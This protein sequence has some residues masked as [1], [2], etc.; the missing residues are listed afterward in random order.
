MNGENYTTDSY[1]ALTAAKEAID[2]LA[3]QDK[4]AESGEGERVYPERFIEAKDAFSHAMDSLI[5]VTDLKAAI[6]LEDQV[7][8]PS[9]Y[10]EESYAAFADAVENGKH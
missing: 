10:T 3:A 2:V 6:A 8:D 9:I 4:A 7:T 1:A 5:D